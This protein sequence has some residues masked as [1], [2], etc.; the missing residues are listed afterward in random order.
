MK[1]ATS[2]IDLQVFKRGIWNVRSIFCHK[3]SATWGLDKHSHMCSSQYTHFSFL[4]MA[5]IFCSVLVLS[6]L[7]VWT[8]LNQ[9]KL[10]YVACYAQQANIAW[11]TV[12]RIPVLNARHVLKT[13]SLPYQT[14]TLL[15]KNVQ[16][17]N[18]IVLVER[19]WSHAHQRQTVDVNVQMINTGTVTL[20]GVKIVENVTQASKQLPPVKQMRTQS[21]RSAQR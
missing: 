4:F 18:V 15:V 10:D 2:G 14:T 1:N 3:L 16:V 7:V 12:G 19:S 8:S 21:V 5:F 17:W 11:R 9:R 6:I 13:N 20:Y